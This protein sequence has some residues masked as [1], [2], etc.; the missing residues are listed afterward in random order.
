MA[1]DPNAVV[2]QN[3]V[4]VQSVAEALS[5]A[6]VQIAAEILIAEEAQNALAD[7]CVAEAQNDSVR[8]AARNVE[9]NAAQISPSAQLFRARVLMAFP[10]ASQNL[11][12][13]NWAKDFLLVVLLDVMTRFVGYH[14]NVYHSHHPAA[15]AG[16]LFRVEY[17]A[18][19]LDA[20]H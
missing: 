6:V 3:A 9:P 19:P 18:L 5:A 4:V 2:D 10:Q 8:N 7:R 16:Q 11:V 20:T 1:G 13:P 12:D 15:R 14:A 17:Q